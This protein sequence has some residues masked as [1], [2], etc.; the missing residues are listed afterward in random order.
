MFDNGN[1]ISDETMENLFIPYYT[2]KSDGTGLGLSISKHLV[3]S[4]LN[5]SINLENVDNGVK[6]TIEIRGKEEGYHE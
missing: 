5:G 4:K 6:C 2:T 3:E 1:K